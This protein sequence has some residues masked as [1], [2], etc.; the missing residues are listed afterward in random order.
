MQ[1]NK[2]FIVI[3]I[4]IALV[5]VLVFSQ[6]RNTQIAKASQNASSGSKGDAIQIIRDL[7]G[8]PAGVKAPNLSLDSS[9]G[10]KISLNDYRGKTL[11]LSVWR[12]NCPYCQREAPGIRAL[13]EEM[14]THPDI[15]FL[16]LSVDSN[17]KDA[18]A[19]IK[20]YK[21][22]YPVLFDPGA[23]TIQYSA[24]LATEGVP[25]V[26]IISPSGIVTGRFEGLHEWGVP[27]TIQ[28]MKNLVSIL[29]QKS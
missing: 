1:R 12:S 21:I 16:G 2:A 18:L 7:D 19:F 3:S 5:A 28:K 4:I 23:A 6:F 26:Y 8:I 17:K 14:K 9:T 20:K 13:Y 24:A 29:A 25:I 10:R 22:A 15:E 11:F 27:S